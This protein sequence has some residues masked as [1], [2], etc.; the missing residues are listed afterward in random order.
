MESPDEFIKRPDEHFQL[1]KEIQNYQEVLEKCKKVTSLKN[2]HKN[3]KKHLK[4]RCDQL[5]EA[6]LSKVQLLIPPGVGTDHNFSI[7][8]FLSSKIQF[9]KIQIPII[10]T[11]F[12][13]QSQ[14]SF[15]RN[16]RDGEILV[17][18][19]ELS[20]QE[21]LNKLR[22]TSN[23]GVPVCIAKP[24][25]G[26]LLL[27]DSVSNLSRF[28]TEKNDFQGIIQNF[29]NGHT[30]HLSLVR[31]HWHSGGKIKGYLIGNKEMLNSE[32]QILRKTPIKTRPITK[33]AFST[34]CSDE[35]IIRNNQ[36]DEECIKYASKLVKKHKRAQLRR[37]SI[38]SQ[39]NTQV[40]LTPG[41]LFSIYENYPVHINKDKKS[42]LEELNAKCKNSNINLWCEDDNADLLYL[43]ERDAE[44]FLISGTDPGKLCVTELKNVYPSILKTLQKTVDLVNQHIKKNKKTLMELTLDFIKDNNNWVLLKADDIMLSESTKEFKEIPSPY[45]KISITSFIPPLSSQY[46]KKID[47]LCM[48]IQNIPSKRVDPPLLHTRTMSTSFQVIPIRCQQTKEKPRGSFSKVREKLDNF[49]KRTDDFTDQE[50]FKFDSS[51]KHLIESY[52]ESF[53]LC[54]SS[55]KNFEAKRSLNSS[56]LSKNN[57][58]VKKQPLKQENKYEVNLKPIIKEYNSMMIHVRRVHLKKKKPL[59]EIYG[60]EEFFRGLIKTFCQKIVPLEAINKRISAMSKGSFNGMFLKGLGCVF[61]SNIS[62]EFRQ[63]VRQ[64]HKHLSIEIETYKSFCLLFVTV[65]QEYRIAN[66]DLEVISDNLS[67]FAGA[68]CCQGRGTPKI[69]K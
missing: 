37:F 11:L 17:V 6:Q 57:A 5:K 29:V 33:A 68:I 66:E 30:D 34:E 23:G 31:V 52:S 1:T 59:S 2:Y 39:H 60:G 46:G 28:L 50:K 42:F 35:D 53:Q 20:L 27:F 55:L 43:N 58:K 54:A 67:S 64:K 65:L 4:K 7:Y 21:F 36:T 56:E 62:L 3:Y 14:Y 47:L 19:G 51:Q 44:K 12:I 69:G 13:S 22:Y 61:N 40:E 38:L 10:D 9:K 8:K 24:E 26:K 16:S 49:I 32:T 45:N 18:K 63:Q 25:N 48:K 41:D 15:M